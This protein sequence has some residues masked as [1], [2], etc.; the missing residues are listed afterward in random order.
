[1]TNS[2]R[3][4]LNI[5]EVL[6]SI[7]IYKLYGLGIGFAN[8]HSIASAL[9]THCPLRTDDK[10]LLSSAMTAGVKL[11]EPVQNTLRHQV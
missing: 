8:A 3:T 4:T 1:M 2:M 9:L 6:S 11:F 10:R 7:E 5:D